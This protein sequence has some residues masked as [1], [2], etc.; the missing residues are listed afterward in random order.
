MA[1]KKFKEETLNNVF[2]QVMTMI[3]MGMLLIPNDYSVENALRHAWFKIQE[4]QGGKN[5]NY[6]YALDICTK[7][8]IALSLLKMCTDGLTPAKNQCGFLIRKKGDSFVLNYMKEYQGN[9]ALAKRYSGVKRVDAQVVYDGEKYEAYVNDG[10]KS[11]MHEPDMA[12]IDFDK[13]KGAYCVITEADGTKQTIEMSYSQIKSAW[14]M[15]AMKGEGDVHKNFT[16]QMCLKSVINRACKP[17]INSSSDAAILPEGGRKAIV[18]SNEPPKMAIEKPEKQEP[19]QLEP[20]PEENKT[21]PE[22][23]Q[24]PY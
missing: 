11:V 5:A 18:Q 23:S 6:K 16:D 21:E 24:D 13:I 10:I 17:Y 14:S 8:S 12:K 3:E 22:A 4:T 15:G 1:E 7:E 2:T 19:K 20:K 9:I